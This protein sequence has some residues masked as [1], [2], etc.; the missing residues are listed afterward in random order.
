[1][2]RT[3][4]PKRSK[5]SRGCDPLILVTKW[6]GTFIVDEKS[7]RIIEKRIMPND[8]DEVAQKLAIIQR[9]GI[10]P[11]EKEI[12]S[13]FERVYVSDRR[14]AEIGK[15]SFYDSSFIKPESFGFSN[16]MMR[17]VMMRLGKLRSSE[18]IS[19]DVNL[20][21]AIRSLDDCIETAN[22]LNERLHEWYGMHFPEL[23]DLVKDRRYA[24]LVAKHGSREGILDEL[25]VSMSS[26]GAELDAEDMD[27]IVRLATLLGEIYSQKE[28]TE[29]YITGIISEICPNMCAL[30]DGTLAARL[31]SLTGSLE[32]LSSLPS[33]TIQL[34]G[35][36]KAMFKHL[37]SN[38]KLPKHGIIYTHP[39]IHKAPYWQRG[40]ISRALAGKILIAA[41]VDMYGGEFIGDRIK[42]EFEDR[43]GEIQRKYPNAPVR[44]SDS[45]KGGKRRGKR[46]TKP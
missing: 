41:K 37:R 17:D 32:R 6:F 7:N 26:I 14:M 19:R 30:V 42:G 15:V 20:V 29:G 13:K 24:A 2:S 4:L 18:P 28:E 25:G 36:E 38:K 44:K 22:L 43:I 40:K 12:S 34:L 16:D 10:L 46:P 33:S 8:P 23:A 9:G 21:Q 3:C 11:E 35:A 45:R 1:M 39:S 27:A 5:S 31:I